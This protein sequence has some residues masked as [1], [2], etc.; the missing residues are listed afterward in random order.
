MADLSY[1]EAEEE[2]EKEDAAAAAEAATAQAAA[3][4]AVAASTAGREAADGPG[5]APDKSKGQEGKGV[6]YWEALLRD[7]YEMER[8]L[9]FLEMGKGRRTR[10]QVDY[11]VPDEKTLEFES[12]EEK[13]GAR[14]E[15]EE[16]EGGGGEEEEEGGLVG[17]QERKRAATSDG[18]G[19]V[20]SASIGFHREA[21]NGLPSA[22]HAVSE[23]DDL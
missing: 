19:G 17:G 15:E 1:A 22:H 8:E 5:Y 4:A 6:E 23:A 7:R 20:E 13:E 14:G 2:K 16:G 10:R 18:R 9:E 11:R 3:A 21:E 12:E